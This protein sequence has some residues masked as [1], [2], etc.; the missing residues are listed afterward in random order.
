MLENGSWQT[1]HRE[2]K[3]TAEQQTIQQGCFNVFKTDRV[4]K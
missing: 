1:N 4:N 2:S 3:Q